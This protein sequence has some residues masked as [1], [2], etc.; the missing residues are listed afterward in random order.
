MYKFEEQQP[1]LLDSLQQV[2]SPA[3]VKIIGSPKNGVYDCELVHDQNSIA[4]NIHKWMIDKWGRCPA[5]IT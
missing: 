3:P 2:M 4:P 1:S 5:V